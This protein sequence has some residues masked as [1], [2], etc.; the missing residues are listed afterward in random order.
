MNSKVLLFSKNYRVA[1]KEWNFAKDLGADSMAFQIQSF[2]LSHY[3]PK[4]IRDKDMGIF[5]KWKKGE[6]GFVPP[7]KSLDFQTRRSYL[8][9][10]NLLARRDQS[11]LYTIGKAYRIEVM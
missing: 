7:I 2:Y 3:F 10:Y 11:I 6:T 4:K 5:A 1:L 9:Q 8:N